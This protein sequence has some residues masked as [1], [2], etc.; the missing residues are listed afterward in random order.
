MVVTN[1]CL[2]T[3]FFDT[4]TRLYTCEEDNFCYSKQIKRPQKVKINK[5]RLKSNSCKFFSKKADHYVKPHFA[6]RENRLTFMGN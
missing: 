1:F 5:K 4:L 3:H 6:A 2:F